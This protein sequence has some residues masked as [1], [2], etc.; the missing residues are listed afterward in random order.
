MQPKRRK[1][2]KPL[3]AGT[4]ALQEIRYYQNSVDLLI[5]KRPFCR[6]VREI[7]VNMKKHLR[8]QTT[9]MACLQE[10][11]EHALVVLMELTNL[12]TLHRG[13]ITITPKDMVLAKRIIRHFSKIYG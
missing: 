7:T 2:G 5:R 10:A 11:T 9:A 4:R 13:R 12:C 1:N 6:L 3:T 8:F